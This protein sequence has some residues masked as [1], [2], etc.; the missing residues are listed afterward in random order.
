MHRKRP[1]GY[2]IAEVVVL[3]FIIFA[4]CNHLSGCAGK[5]LVDSATGLPLTPDQTASVVADELAKD[6]KFLHQQVSDLLLTGTEEQ[7]AWL[8]QNVT[9]NL[10]DAKHLI[11][12]YNDIVVLWRTQ[13]EMPDDLIGKEQVI[14]G[15][16]ET[17]LI[18]FIGR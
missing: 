18:T 5:Q 15:L 7:K 3:V 9:Q 10:D 17:I 11:G 13:G 2:L 4:M 1:I 16:L 14:R 8:Y 6:I 12:A